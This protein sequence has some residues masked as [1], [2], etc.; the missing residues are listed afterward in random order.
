M[1]LSIVISM[2]IVFE[3]P[4]VVLGQTSDCPQQRT[5]V[6]Y[7]AR[8]G[9][10]FPKSITTGYDASSEQ[11]LDGIYPIYVDLVLTN[12]DASLFPNTDV[13]HGNTRRFR[14]PQ[15]LSTQ[16]PWFMGHSGEFVVVA[17]GIG[18]ADG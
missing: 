6:V 9:G 7:G 4:L 15:L 11:H 3:A 18:S 5:Y 8:L 17:N 10:D 14:S 13:V 1:R 12:A 2:L 16:T